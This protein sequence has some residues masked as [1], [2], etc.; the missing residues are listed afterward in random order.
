MWNNIPRQILAKGTWFL[1]LHTVNARRVVWRFIFL[2]TT[3]KHCSLT[4]I[5]AEFKASRASSLPTERI[6]SVSIR[7]W[8]VLNVHRLNIS[9]SDSVFKF[10]VNKHLFIH[11]NSDCGPINCIVYL[12]QT[13]TVHYWSDLIKRLKILPW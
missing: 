7:K 11:Y 13:Y 12:L 4:E 5:G 2:G 8:S 6:T 9:E 3:N 10:T 1:R